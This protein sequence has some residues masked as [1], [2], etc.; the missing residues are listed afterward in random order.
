[1]RESD[2][3]ARLG[4][5]EFAI[6]QTDMGNRRPPVHSPTRSSSPSLTHLIQGNKINISASIGV[7]PF[8][9]A[10]AS[11]DL[12]LTQADLALYRSK[13]EGRNQYHFHTEDLDNQ[14][15]ERVTLAEDL[16][17]AVEEGQLEL[18]YQPQVELVSGKITGMEAL[19]RWHHPKAGS[20]ERRCLHSACG[21]GGLDDD[22]GQVGHQ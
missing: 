11:P 15:L 3:I 20:L 10:S 21:K 4:G 5:D 17:N 19:V 9:E 13:D 22:V 8:T 18:Y 2:V 1:M 12:M 16:R 14:V 6:L 7:C